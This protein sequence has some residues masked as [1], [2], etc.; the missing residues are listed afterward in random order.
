MNEIKEMKLR[1]CEIADYLLLMYSNHDNKNAKRLVKDWLKKYIPLQ[2]MV[3][4]VNEN[5]EVDK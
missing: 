2:I 5:F 4:I 1:M 3:E